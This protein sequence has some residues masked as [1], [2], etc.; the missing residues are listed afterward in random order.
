MVRRSTFWGSSSHAEQAPTQT[1]NGLVTERVLVVDDE[2]LIR[3]SVRQNLERAGY[4]VVEAGDGEQAMHIL[5]REGADLVLLDVRLPGKSGLQV[6]EHVTTQYPEIPAI[7]MTAYSSVEEAVGAMKGG[8]F[9][10]LVKPFNQDEVLV[11]VRKALET[12]RMQ[13]EVQI[14]RRQQ[15]ECHNLENLVGKSERMLEICDLV[16]KVAISSAATV[17]IQGESGTG[18]DLIAKSIHFTSARADKEFM[19]ITCSAI[20]E[21]LLESELMGHERG[22]F[23]DA[24]QM[25]RGLLELADRGTLFLDEIGDMGMGLQAKLL[26]FLEE[27]TL[28]RVGGTRDIQ[29]DVRIVAATNRD[30]EQ[31]VQQ[32]TFREDLF[33]RLNVIGI[34][35]PPLRERREDIPMLVGRFIKMFNR[36]LRKGTRAFTPEAMDCL[37]RHE[38]PGN[39]RELRNVIERAMILENKEF[40]AEQD[41]P[42]E[43]RHSCAPKRLEGNSAA[44]G[45]ELPD[46]GYAL[47][48]M[49]E[50][51][52]RQALR[53]TDGNQSRAAALLNISRDALRYK[54]KKHGLL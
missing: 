20:P 21:T 50:E 41:L 53:K 2:K 34:K 40:L 46:S 44:F 14:L 39:V 48:R 1:E 35:L 22:A 38:W 26:R 29:V 51:M 16:R 4:Q 9:D 24:R 33:Y 15:R 11:L 3:W 27:K 36:E 18:K 32:G 43:I 45:F 7:L 10:Y 37:M 54:M 52:L 30:L 13:R 6:L 28:R 19:N 25:K 5:D 31:A 49:E 8:A 12:T 42:V 47:R 23:T 17:L